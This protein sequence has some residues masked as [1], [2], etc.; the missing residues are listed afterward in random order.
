MSRRRAGGFTLLELVVA[1]A[2]AVVLFVGVAAVVGGGFRAWRKAEEMAEVAREGTRI[3]R[4]LEDQLKRAIASETFRFEGMATGLQFVMAE[5]DGPVQVRWTTQPSVPTG[6]GTITCTLQPLV[7]DPS[8]PEAPPA[9]PWQFS[10]ID[11]LALAFP[12][13]AQ[14]AAGFMWEPTWSATNADHVPQAVRVILRLKGARGAVVAL[15]RI[16]TL[17]HGV[18]G[19]VEGSSPS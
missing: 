6:Q 8:A 7:P 2:I 3:L 18:V 12:V 5:A 1:S 4:V 15:E 11:H 16:V 19:T 10:W 14:G 13:A 17:P 9:R